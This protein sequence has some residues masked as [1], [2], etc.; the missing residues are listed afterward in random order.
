MDAA[1]YNQTLLE[2]MLR[3]AG[4]MRESDRSPSTRK[5]MEKWRVSYVVSRQRPGPLIKGIVV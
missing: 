1:Q 5:D 2:I 3:D 4:T